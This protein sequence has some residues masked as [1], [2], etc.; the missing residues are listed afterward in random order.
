MYIHVYTSTHV[1]TCM[2]MYM[3]MYMCNIGT[4]Y[5]YKCTYMCVHVCTCVILVVYTS[6]HVHTVEGKRKVTEFCLV[7]ELL[8]S[9][10]RSQPDYRQNSH[11]QMENSN[12]DLSEFLQKSV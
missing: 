2:Y 7:P 8:Q 4:V 10:I 11:R 1:H 12:R 3:C 9:S 6:T 5:K